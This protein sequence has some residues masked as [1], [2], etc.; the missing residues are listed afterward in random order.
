MTPSS[1]RWCADAPPSPGN[2][3]QNQGRR[4]NRLPVGRVAPRLTHH[5]LQFVD[6]DAQVPSARRYSATVVPVT[7][8][9]TADCSLVDIS[10]SRPTTS[11][12]SLM[13]LTSEPM[14][15]SVFRATAVQPLGGGRFPGHSIVG[16]EKDHTQ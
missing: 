2:R 10:R 4:A 5:L 12:A 14:F 13:S 9:R 15:E 11:P 8:H 16:V 7:S 6:P 1:F 3:G